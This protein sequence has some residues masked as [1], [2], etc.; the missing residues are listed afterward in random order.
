MNNHKTWTFGVQV[1]FSAVVILLCVVQIGFQRDKDNLALYWGGLSSV[2]AYWLPSPTNSKEDEQ[3][4]VSNRY[5]LNQMSSNGMVKH[6][7]ATQETAAI[8]M[9]NE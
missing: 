7:E 4:L 6:S 2:L 3:L 8:K 1:F 5:S 9:T